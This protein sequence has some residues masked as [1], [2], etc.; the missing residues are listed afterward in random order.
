MER[1]SERGWNALAAL[2]EILRGEDDEGYIPGAFMQRTVGRLAEP[3][4]TGERAAMIAAAR[5]NRMHFASK[6]LTLRE[7]LNKLIHYDSASATFRVDGRG[8]HYLVLGG[9]RQKRQWVAELLIAEMSRSMGAAARA[10]RWH[11]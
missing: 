3:V 9:A 10:I 4:T 8:A 11:P 2:V 6:P 7:A 5:V 1:S